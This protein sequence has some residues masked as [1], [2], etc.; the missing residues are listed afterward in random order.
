M[1]FPKGFEVSLIFEE[2]V[3]DPGRVAEIS[4]QTIA[5]TWI[6][7]GAASRRMLL[8]GVPANETITLIVAGLAKD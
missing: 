5:H 8:F 4:V 1:P 2:N 3:I 6:E 7:R